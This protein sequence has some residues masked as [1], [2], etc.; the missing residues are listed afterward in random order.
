MADPLD[1]WVLKPGAGSGTGP[2]GSSDDAPLSLDLRSLWPLDAERRCGC[3]VSA[4]CFH[5]QNQRA[6]EPVGTAPDVVTG[7]NRQVRCPAR[8]MAVN[9]A[10]FNA[11]APNP[12]LNAIAASVTVLCESCRPV[13]ANTDTPGLTKAP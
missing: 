4:M 7:W 11:A 2:A 8:S 1:S 5:S 6:H 3:L 12:L 9:A 10:M 13:I